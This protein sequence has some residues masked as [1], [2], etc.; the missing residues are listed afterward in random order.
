M[1]FGGGITRERAQISD[2]EDEVDLEG[3]KEG[4]KIDI[5]WRILI[6]WKEGDQN[7][8]YVLIIFSN[9]D[10]KTRTVIKSEK[11]RNQVCQSLGKI[12]NDGTSKSIWENYFELYILIDNKFI[13]ALYWTIMKKETDYTKDGTK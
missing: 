6:L 2:G 11:S 7:W 4:E 1:L 3:Q 10:K 12:R 8:L 9:R 5:R 13:L